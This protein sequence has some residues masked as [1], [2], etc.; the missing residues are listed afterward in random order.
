MQKRRITFKTS[1]RATRSIV[2][3]LRRSA[4][5]LFALA[6]C[7]Q[8]PAPLPTPV[9]VPLREA[10]GLLFVNVEIAGKTHVFL[11]DSGAQADVID[12]SVAKSLGLNPQNSIEIR[13]AGRM[14]SPGSVLL[15]EMRLGA[16][17]F[18]PHEVTVLQLPEINSEVPCDGIL[19]FTFFSSAELR[20]DP[21]RDA[22]TIAPPG[23]LPP[24]GTRVSV[25]VDHRFPEVDAQ[26]QGVATR[27]IVDTG[28]ANEL[29][30]FKSF[31]DEH[32]G[33]VQLARIGPVLNRGIGGSVGAVGAIVGSV[34]VGPYSLYNRYANVVLDSAGSFNDVGDGGN[35]GYGSLK[36]FVMTFDLANG[37][38]YLQKAQGFDDGRG[39]AL[40]E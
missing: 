11:L 17:T 9:T 35:I 22:L 21:T 29:L 3:K 7:A 4:P 23:A 19:G 1:W 33:L 18:A 12:V 2:R 8:T 40:T 15:P 5:L 14:T 32:H 25:D 26:M 6:L 38:L 34:R 37:A 24:D 16:A 27:L 31:I 39:R 28:N 30:V 10:G 13:G 36:N 20:F